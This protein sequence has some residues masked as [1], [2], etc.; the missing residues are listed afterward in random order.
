D[1]G[2]DRF[3]YK[4]EKGWTLI[5]SIVVKRTELAAFK[6]QF[7][8]YE[9][10][11]IFDVSEMANAL[12]VSV[13][14][15]FNYLIL[16]SSLVVLFSLLIIYG[17]IE[18]ALFSFLPMVVSWVWII[19]IAG[20]FEIQFNFVNIIVA[21]FIFGLGDDFSIFVTDGLI[22]K[23]K[24]KSDSL[25]SYRSAI[26]LS[27]I[28]TIIGTGALYFAQH[29]AI[30]SIAVISVVGIACIML[31]TLVVQPSI[32]RFF[33]TNRTEKKKSPV[34]LLGL[35]I[36]SVLFIYFFIGCIL[37][38]LFLLILIPFPAPKKSKRNLLNFI[39]S[40][41]AKSTI[42][43]GFHVKKQIIN[44]ESLNFD[45]PS[46][47]VANHSSFLDILLMIM[48]N[49]KVII[50]VKKWV[51]NS[52]VF[53]LFIRYSGYLFVAEGA[54]YNM[55]LMKDRVNDGY[56]IMIFPEGTR[57]RDG[58]IK[59]FHKGAFYLAQE[60]KLD[61]QPI[62]IIG[63]NYVNAKN[64]FIIKSGSLILV[65]LDRICPGDD[66]YE[67][68]F[69]LFTKEVT[70]IMRDEM[71]EFKR[72]NLN[73]KY[74]KNRVGYN[75]LY[76]SPI[77]EWYVRI[78]WQFEAKNFEFYDELIDDRN[79]IYDIGCGL[80]YLSYYL[81][82]RDEDRQIIGVDYDE[83]KIAI[84]QNG[85]D[86]TDQLS[87]KSQDLREVE[88]NSP[89]VVFFNDVLHYISLED[90]LKVL[91]EVADNLSDE[92]ILIVRD[93]ITDLAD[94]HAVTKKTEKYS[95]RIVNFNK[96]SGEL[97]FFSSKDIFKFA[98]DRNFKCEM[99][100][101]SDKTSNVLFVLRKTTND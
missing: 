44:E 59:R 23:Y 86:K 37:I 57:S 74:Y 72:A 90:Q 46:V 68:R 9:G 78:K 39:V 80:G 40:K 25:S 92:G 1:L 14:N 101:Q 35:L 93:G 13:Q 99:I 26:V 3:V 51:Y 82:Y 52:P 10:V 7:S 98:E 42:Y 66:V 24:T 63:A 79:K 48:L 83:D 21:T 54:E 31:V 87:F 8:E 60:L 97:S 89:D 30:H 4:T 20:M 15:D 38:N 2:L 45:K 65:V 61:I 18:L 76:K 81:H 34:T 69:G 56:S 94:R 53:G 28:T 96:T 88:F 6:S 64:D 58:K 49:P 12:M 100:E 67:K 29:P 71:K 33:I 77:T 75:Y 70:Q 43:L 27:G 50:M 36:S 91:N 22:Q 41:L 84:A 47:I 73:A 11:Y 19:A 85:Y 17:R 62:L 5:S 32:F 55:D 95:T 16:F